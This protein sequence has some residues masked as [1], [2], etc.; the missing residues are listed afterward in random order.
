MQAAIHL[1]GAPTS[2]GAHWPGQE[3][4]PQA[5]RAAGIVPLLEERGMA[6]IDRGDL[7][8]ERWR[9][10]RKEVPGGTVNNADRV[11]EYARRVATE[12]E[13]VARAGGFPVVLGGDCTITVGAFAGLLRAGLDPALIYVDGGYDLSSPALYAAGIM[14]SMGSAHLMGLPGT[15]PSLAGI[16]P[17]TPMLAQDRWVAFGHGTGTADGPEER[18]V[19]QMGLKHIPGKVARGRSTDAAREALARLPSD[20]ASFH[21][22]FDVDVIDFFDLPVADVPI[23]GD[24]LPFADAVAAVG[25]FASDPRCVGLTITEFNPDHG[26]PDGS[27]ALRLASGIA[28]ALGRRASLAASA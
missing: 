1:I 15:L 27:D 3:K 17:R 21:L 9:V 14:D 19:E 8:T 22:H 25:V 23:F 6:V 2:A 10:D 12:V 13:D 4:G 7:P 11:V 5:Y 24:G 28:D 18:L 16:G 26:A 20:V